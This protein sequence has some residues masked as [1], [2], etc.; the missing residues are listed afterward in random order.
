MDQRKKVLSLGGAAAVVVVGGWLVASSVA[1][2]RA[3]DA[4][5]RFLDQYNLRD[6]V[7]W[8]DLSA[9]PLGSA[10]LKDVTI[11]LG[12]GKDAGQVT[13]ERVILSD[14]EN[15]ADR[16]TAH[17][18]MRAVSDRDGFSP[19]AQTDL[20]QAGGRTDLPPFSFDLSWDLNGQ[21]DQGG[22]RFSLDQPD[23][24]RGS[25]NLDLTRV[26]DL[27]RW[28]DRLGDSKAE[29]IPGMLGGAAFFGPL[30]VL[31]AVGQKLQ[32]LEI[33]A[34][35]ASVKDEGYA[36]RVRALV[37][38]HGFA[39]VPGQGAAAKQRAKWLQE[40]ADEGKKQCK[41]DP[42]AVFDGAPLQRDDC[43][44]LLD[45]LTGGS[46]SLSMNM[47]PARPV[48]LEQ[49]FSGGGRRDA[50]RPLRLLEMRLDN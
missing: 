50:Y 35:H 16:K 17:I 15:S 33:R 38:R 11:R 48:S 22:L 4:L 37:A 21:A 43:L 49:L 18:E 39:A 28:V 41:H 36:Q 19:L 7:H 26:R 5:Y 42:E 14:L 27:V 13:I 12:G 6:V 3:E 44:A 25:F 24:F 46:S 34:V 31:A 47:A 20:I 8:R 40:K 32:Q 10:T 1:T 45:F 23:A 30:G 2:N 29:E 9:S